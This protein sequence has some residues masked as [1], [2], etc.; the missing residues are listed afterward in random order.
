MS[1]TMIKMLKN[2]KQSLL[3]KFTLYFASMNQHQWM[4]TNGVI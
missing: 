1:H 3:Q 4:E 2:K